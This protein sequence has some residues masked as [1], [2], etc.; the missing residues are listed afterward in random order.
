MKVPLAFAVC[1][2]VLLLAS[3]IGEP[4]KV[5]G[6][7]PVRGET[8]LADTEG[9]GTGIMLFNFIPIGQNERFR[10][11]YDRALKRVPGATR[12]ANVTISENWFW[13]YIL[14]GYTTKVRGTAVK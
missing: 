1:V 5:D 10:V 4:L 14:N 7:P 6:G 8:I 3:C 13:A 9:S 12:L 11:A 2:P